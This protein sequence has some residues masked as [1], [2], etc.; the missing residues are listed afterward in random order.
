MGS[1]RTHPPFVVLI[2]AN[3]MNMAADLVAIGSGVNLL[4]AGPTWLWAL[5]AGV[6]VT[7]TLATGS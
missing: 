4:H 5:V 1:T 7:V 2:V 6:V 3:T